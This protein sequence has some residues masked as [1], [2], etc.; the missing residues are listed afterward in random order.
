MDQ[1]IKGRLGSGAQ[2]KWLSRMDGLILSVLFAVPL[3][4]SAPFVQSD[5][6]VHDIPMTELQAKG[7]SVL[8]GLTL[9]SL[10]GG[11][12]SGKTP[13][14]QV[15]FK[16]L[17]VEVMLDRSSFSPGV[18]DGRMGSGA[19]KALE[20]FLCQ[21]R[22]RWV[23]EPLLVRYRV[24]AEDAR[25]PF[26][27]IPFGMA[28]QASLE[29][30]GYPSILEFLAEKFHC[31]P[32]LLRQL[33]REAHFHAG[34]DLLVPNVNVM[35]LPGPNGKRGDAAR[36][37]LQGIAERPLVVVT[38]GKRSSALVVA[39]ANGSVVFYAPVTTGSEHDPLPIGQWKVN[40]VT[41]NP[42]F[43]YNP[44]LF[45]NSKPSDK[46][47]VIPAGPRNPI[48]LVWVDLSKEHY[49]LHGTP[50]PSLIGRTHSHGCVRLTNWDA[51]RLAALVK[52]GTRVL[53]VE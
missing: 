29:V 51:L 18:I 4:A 33:N 23:V 17:Q 48:G 31:T 49:G 20:M 24:T 26:F 2:A 40:G 36:N 50:N 52:P 42:T 41:L 28:S 7:S 25:G 5:A 22:R 44:R 21:G 37:A 10:F 3:G 27:R 30:L 15:N 1:W 6:E 34:E 45:W 8:V 43:L 14:E 53:F 47:V 11:P 46:R 39:D 12:L 32:M 16:A 9:F 38:V 13:L 35:V 19:R